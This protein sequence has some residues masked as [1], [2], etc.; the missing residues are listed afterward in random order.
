MFDYID[1]YSRK[2]KNQIR[3][4]E[5]RFNNKNRENKKFDA[6]KRNQKINFIIQSFFVE[7][8]CF[9]NCLFVIVFQK[10]KTNYI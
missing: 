2:V 4:F 9:V 6:L 3:S 8:H 7:S 10:L 5:N 1:N